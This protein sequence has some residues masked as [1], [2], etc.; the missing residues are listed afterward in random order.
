MKAM[1]KYH[2]LASPCEATLQSTAT[3]LVGSDKS[4][5]PFLAHPC[6]SP[7]ALRRGGFRV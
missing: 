7:Q 3:K 4:L 1:R 2:I 6:F 5:Q